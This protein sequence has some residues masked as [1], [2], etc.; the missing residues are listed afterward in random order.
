MA[1][2]KL[3]I[4]AT[5]LIAKHLSGVGHVVLE[6]VRALDVNEFARAYEITLF[7]P[8]DEKGKLDRYSFQ[9]LQVA[10]LPF[11]HKFLSLFS[12]IAFSPPIDLFLGKGVYI[13]PNFRN[14]PLARSSSITYIHDVAFKKYPE[15]IEPR[16]LHFLSTHIKRWL[17]QTD[18]I[19]GV[20]RST[21]DEIGEI[22]GDDV[23]KKTVVIRNAV[24]KKAYRPQ[25]ERVIAAVKKKYHLSDKYVFFVSNI[26]PRKNIITLVD[27][28]K[29]TSGLGDAELF[30]VGGDGWLNTPINEAIRRAQEEGFK[31]RRNTQ[32]VP[33]ED[34]PAL[35]QGA[36]AVVVPSWHEGFGLP[37]IQAVMSGGRV[38]ASDIPALREAAG[39]VDEQVVAFFDP[40]DVR[41]LSKLL[42]TPKTVTGKIPAVR[43]WSDV[44]RDLVIVATNLWEEKK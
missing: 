25:K 42:E 30:I 20:S 28:F 12:R 24:D 5:P 43:T 31:V 9:H 17:R 22:F 2:T 35:M 11:P 3:F 33:D 1:R 8:M 4:D 14:W 6:T 7:L 18:C 34:L 44:A 15:Y 32:F 19:V 27:A 29:Q 21:V 37:L 16:N 41:R 39:M 23:A 38:I 36:W 26:E 10:Y 13:F 40:S